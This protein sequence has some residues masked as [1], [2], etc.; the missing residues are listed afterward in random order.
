MNP[1]NSFRLIA[2]LA[3]ICGSLHGQ[4]LSPLS[5]FMYNQQVY[6]PASFGMNTSQFNFSTF[7][8]IQWS[9]I[10]GAPFMA[11][12]WG[13][14]RLRR[15]NMALGL[16]VGT[17]G[18][19]GYQNTDLNANY[20]YYLT[21]SRKLKLAAG[22]R[23]GFSSVSFN[24][25]DFNIWDG[26][27]EVINNS[28]YQKIVPKLGT[29][30]QLNGRKFYVSVA[31]PD[32]FSSPKVSITGDTASSFFKRQRNLVLMSGAKIRLG[33]Q[34]N[35]RPNIGLFYYTDNGILGHINATFEIKDYFWAGLTV[36]T[37]R[38]AT[39]LL[40]T[41]IS[42][43][44]RFGYAFETQSLFGASRLNSHELN[45]LVTLDNLFRKKKE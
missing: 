11:H 43:R 24:T 28:T 30:F 14:Y 2:L 7:T 37:Y 21:L 35:L 10:D 22:L 1:T 26:N 29:G 32:L 13:D 44:I 33:D 18:Y 27:D 31:A 17:F 23:A 8:R 39:L 5:N 40:G 38:S 16:N 45:I 42:S 3:F 19:S 34:Y 4:Q 15:E 41:H 6:N 20:A 25:E 9:S 36:S 12:L